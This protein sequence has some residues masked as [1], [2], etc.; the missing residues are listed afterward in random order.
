MKKNALL[1]EMEGVYAKVSL[2]KHIK[3]AYF[4]LLMLYKQVR[5]MGFLLNEWSVD[6]AIQALDPTIFLA[7][8]K[9]TTNT[10]PE[11][12]TVTTKNEAAADDAASCGR[13]EQQI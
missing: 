1:L 5:K 3:L 13:G 2:K 4:V 6:S 7:T 10:N 11:L 12:A 8:R 9:R